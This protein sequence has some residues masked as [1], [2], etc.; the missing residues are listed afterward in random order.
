MALNI[1]NMSSYQIAFFF[2]LFLAIEKQKVNP[3]QKKKHVGN[4]SLKPLSRS[5]PSPN[6]VSPSFL[7]LKR[8]AQEKKIKPRL[9]T[10]PYYRYGLFLLYSKLVLRIKQKQNKKKERYTINI[11]LSIYGRLFGPFR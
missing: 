4:I 6:N 2:K 3:V 8:P 7:P 9:I 11:F 5:P 10:Y 1:N